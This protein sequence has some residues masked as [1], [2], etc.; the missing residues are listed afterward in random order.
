MSLYS[1]DLIELV[2]RAGPAVDHED[3]FGFLSGLQPRRCSYEVDV[4]P[5]NFRLIALVLVDFLLLFTPAVQKITR[6]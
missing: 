4:N 2:E 3:G 6:L 5:F 1:P